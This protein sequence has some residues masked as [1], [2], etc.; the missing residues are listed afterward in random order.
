MVGHTRM[1]GRMDDKVIKNLMTGLM[2]EEA[3]K[4][5]KDVIELR[6]ETMGKDW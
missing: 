5:M 3:V 4:E 1:Y 6:A 2:V